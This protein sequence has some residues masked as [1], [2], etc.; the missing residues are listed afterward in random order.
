MLTGI[1]LIDLQKAFDTI[2]HEILLQKR[3]A[4][5]FS[6]ENLQWFR[7]YLP[8]Q[9]FLVNIDSKHSDFEKKLLW[10]TARVYLRFPFVF[11]LCEPYAISSH[12]SLT[13]ACRRFM[14]LVPTQKR[15]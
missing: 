7:S 2:D 4:I 9:I 12:M 3:K 1:I 13:F 15:R 8:E 14:H 10:S 5:R 11:D 6:K